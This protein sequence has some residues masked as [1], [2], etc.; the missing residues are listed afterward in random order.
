MT[1]TTPSVSSIHATVGCV[2]YTGQYPHGSVVP[3]G[4]PVESTE[5]H[6]SLLCSE[7]SRNL[8]PAQ[9]CLEFLITDSD[10]TVKGGEDSEDRYKVRIH[11]R[12][13]EGAAVTVFVENFEPSFFIRLPDEFSKSDATTVDYDRLKEW[14][15]KQLPEDLRERGETV[16]DCD[17]MWTKLLM[18]FHG[19]KL[20]PHVHVTVTSE[21]CVFKLRSAIERF[22]TTVGDLLSESAQLKCHETKVP[23]ILKFYYKQKRVNSGW[24]HIPAGKWWRDSGSTADISAA[25]DDVSLVGLSDRKDLAPMRIRCW[26]L[27]TVKGSCIGFPDPTNRDDL[28][29]QHSISMYC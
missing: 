6:Q 25:C 28:L 16:K 14:M 23:S 7:E 1:S 24:A 2:P 3:W 29:S 27:E 22:P 4:V 19:S 8:D 9:S 10:T 15:Q 21:E 26:D 13:K 17:I 12:T 20:F 11:G 18:G 5:F